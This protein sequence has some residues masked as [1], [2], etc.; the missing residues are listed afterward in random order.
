[1]SPPGPKRARRARLLGPVARLLLPPLA[2]AA[3]QPTLAASAWAHPC[4][5]PTPQSAAV[6]L[7]H[8]REGAV[9]R[10]PA[11]A[12]EG[13]WEVR[14]ERSA[15]GGAWIH[16]PAAAVERVALERDVLEEARVRERTL[17]R[18]R[19]LAASAAAL[20]EARAAHAGWL[21]DEGLVPEALRALDELLEE[22]PD[23]PRARALCLDARLALPLPALAAG[24]AGADDGGADLEPFLASA[25]RGDGVLREQAAARLRAAL[26]PREPAEPSGS[27]APL[28]VAALDRALC[29]ELRHGDSRRRALAAFLLRRGLP[30]RAL[31]ELLAR[32]TADGSRAVRLE[33][34]R[35]LGDADDAR[36]LG[37]LVRLL[38]APRPETS[39]RAVEALADI[40]H[41]AAV[42][43]LIAFL[44]RSRRSGA[45]GSGSVGFGTWTAVVGDFDV[46]VAQGAAIADPRPRVVGDGVSLDARILGT[47]ETSSARALACDALERITGERPGRSSR[48]WSTWW[49]TH[50]AAWSEAHPPPPDRSAPG[51]PGGG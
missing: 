22:A 40:G 45:G 41:G 8:L 10:A 12:A 46:E 3:A 25:A 47:S 32:S 2:A 51:S 7:L 24:A 33:A 34:N 30:G 29:A 49:Q 27:G 21:L 6:R 13:G 20:Q 4:G 44:E 37:T 42:Q 11:R 39:A 17:L 26:A 38:S 36:V 19:G 5:E 18:G 9:L 35:A 50:G 14:R 31:R 48:A 23:Q 1:M 15:D 28:P 43:P 16:L